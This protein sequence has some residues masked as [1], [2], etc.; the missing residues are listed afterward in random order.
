MLFEL[1]DAEIELTST[2]QNKRKTSDS[3]FNGF[4]KNLLRLSWSQKVDVAKNLRFAD[5]VDL[6][7]NP[8]L[9]LND[10]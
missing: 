1:G 7:K 9:N 10:W 3:I 6:L 5:L 4:E 8:H 2:I